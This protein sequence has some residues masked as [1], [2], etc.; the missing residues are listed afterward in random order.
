MPH[1]GEANREQNSLGQLTAQD[2]IAFGNDAVDMAPALGAHVTLFGLSG[3]GTVAVW[4]A[5]NRPEVDLVAACSPYLGM[6]QVPA[7]LTP[8]VA[9]LADLLPPIDFG[10]GAAAALATGTYAPYSYINNN[11]RA[12]TAFLHLSLVALARASQSPPV[13][14]HTLLIVNDADDTV[15]RDML[16]QLSQVWLRSGASHR[17]YHFEQALRLPHDVIGPDRVDQ[18]TEFVY[19]I[20]VDLV[21]AP[22]P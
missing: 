19:P 18:R 12:A 6:I 11:T 21:A 8:G 9:N 14:R 3:G 5:I 22:L 7:T 4:A 20:L 1:H 15:N 13:A 10:P 17:T 16:E 2:L